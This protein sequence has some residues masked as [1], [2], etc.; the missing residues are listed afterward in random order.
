MKRG[1]AANMAKGKN[2]YTRS[3]LRGISEFL[4]QPFGLRHRTF[5]LKRILAFI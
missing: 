1:Y 4:P 5:S 3:N 2:S